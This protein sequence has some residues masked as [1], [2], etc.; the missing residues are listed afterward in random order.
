VNH[1]DEMQNGM[2]PRNPFSFN[3]PSNPDIL[4]SITTLQG[5]QCSFRSWKLRNESRG[6]TNV[7]DETFNPA[8]LLQ[9]RAAD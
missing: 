3:F 1:A 9:F 2:R 4:R 8:H 7:L 6:K 5:N